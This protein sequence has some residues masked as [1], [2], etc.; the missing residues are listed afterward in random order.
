MLRK[1]GLFLFFK[2]LLLRNKAIRK[3]KTLRLGYMSFIHDSVLGYMNII[4]NNVT[5]INSRLD[6][7]SYVGSNSKIMNADIGKFCSIASDVLIGL[8]KHPTYL[9]ST[10]PGFYSQKV[11]YGF[12]KEY[13]I[14]YSEYKRIYVGHDVWI[15]TRAI[16]LDGVNI[17]I[18][19]I[20]AAGAVVTKDVPPYAIVAGVPAKII[21]Y[22]LDK[23]EASKMLESRWWENKKYKH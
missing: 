5:I 3:N 11:N 2:Y 17:G 22:R 12:E 16:I 15:G 14:N 20:I 10:H 1:T 9:K 8:G 6:D 13:D 19:A 4:Y 7:Y 21:K 18:G 23:S